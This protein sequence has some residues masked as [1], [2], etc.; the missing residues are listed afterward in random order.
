MQTKQI[1]PLSR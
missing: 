1:Q